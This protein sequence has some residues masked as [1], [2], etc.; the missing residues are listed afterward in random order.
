TWPTADRPSEILSR[1]GYDTSRRDLKQSAP[2][3]YQ[4]RTWSSS[5]PPTQ[6]ARGGSCESLEVFCRRNSS[7]RSTLDIFALFLVAVRISHTWF[8]LRYFVKQNHSTGRSRCK[9]R[10]RA[11]TGDFK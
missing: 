4:G 9:Q 7:K 3:M 8:G 6:I 5:L 1:E 10:K 2:S 11:A